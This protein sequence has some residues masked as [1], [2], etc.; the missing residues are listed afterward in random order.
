M[1]EATI[2]RILR[3]TKPFHPFDQLGK[4]GGGRQQNHRKEPQG[5]FNH[6]RSRAPKDRS[7]IRKVLQVADLS[8]SDT[9]FFHEG[10]GKDHDKEEGGITRTF[11][12]K[13]PKGSRAKRAMPTRAAARIPRRRKEAGVN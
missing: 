9:L 7:G 5:R 13:W 8:S 12:A 6:R 11:F 10:D 3:G 2:V 4:G 1:K